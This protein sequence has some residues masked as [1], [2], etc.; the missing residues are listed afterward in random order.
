[1]DLD[2]ALRV[3]E[4]AKLTDKST[5]EEKS[6]YEKW[7]RSNRMSLMIIK[8]SISDTIRGAMPEEENAKKFLSQ[9]A[10]RFVASEKVEACTLLSKLVTMRHNGKGN[11][12]EYI[13][14]MSNLVTKMKALKLEFSQEILVYLVL[15][16][17][18]TQFGPFKINYN[19]QREKWTFNELIAQCVQEEERMKQERTESA[20]LATHSHV[21]SQVCPVAIA[22]DVIHGVRKADLVV[23]TD[24]SCCEH[25]RKQEEE[26]RKYDSPMLWIGIYIAAASLV[27]SVAMAGDVIHGIRQKKLWFPCKFFTMNAASLT[28]LAVATKLPVDLTT[29]MYGI[30]SRVKLISTVFVITVM[31]NFL[32]SFSSMDSNAILV[33]IVAL[34][35]L[36]I[37]IAVN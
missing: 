29:H 2:N 5:A 23:M 14:E 37:T 16:S 11:I 17:L 30:D 18:P 34:G 13:M 9:I 12:R 32:T 19:T 7:E 10:D 4:P 31:G 28:V 6:I 26:Q 15:I 21:A 24:K 25:Y 1:M 33:N 8:H 36:V 22:G 20:H 27:C 35:I 3:D